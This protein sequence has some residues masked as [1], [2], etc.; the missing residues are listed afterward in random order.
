MGE[1]TDQE[2]EMLARFDSATTGRDFADATNEQ[3][4]FDIKNIELA[5]SDLHASWA[6][7]A[8]IKS[9]ARLMREAREQGATERAKYRA[10]D[11]VLARSPLAASCV[12]QGVTAQAA[13]NAFEH[14]LHDMTQEFIR[15][16]TTYGQPAFTS[17]ATDNLA[18]ARADGAEEMRERIVTRLRAFGDP[19]ICDAA[20]SVPVAFDES[21]KEMRAAMLRRQLSDAGD[22]HD[23][24]E[25]DRLDAEI[26]AVERTDE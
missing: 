26:A 22:R 25:C 9:A 6:Y 16:R 2:I 3:R 5:L 24:D 23:R 4:A 13:A 21:E 8:L 14:E 17:L 19:D 15:Y 18:S 1:Y 20:R 12:R 11:V 7:S 10:D